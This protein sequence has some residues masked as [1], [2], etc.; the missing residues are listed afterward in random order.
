[1]TP[2][3]HP[4]APSERLSI[5]GR[6]V[7]AWHGLRYAAADA[8]FAPPRPASGRIEASSLHE[9][10]V[11]PQLPSRLSAAMGAGSANPQSEDAFYLNL[12]APS[13]AQGLP[14]VI[15]IHGGAWM[16]GGGAMTWYDG[17][18][19]AAEGLVVINVNYR[20][21]PLGHLGHPGAHPLPIP[22]ADLLLAL[23]W[24]VDHAG[25]FGGD[26]GRITAMGQSAGG[27]YAHLLT[28]LPETRGLI[29]RAALSSM[30]TRSPWSPQQQI[31]VTA[32]ADSKLGGHLQHAATADVLRAGMSALTREPAQLGHAPSA[33]L[34]VMSAGLPPKLLDPE[35]AAQACHADAV[36]IRFTAHESAA[37]F[38]NTPEQRNATQGQVDEAL[39]RWPEDD[40]PPQLRGE[41]GFHGASSG[42]SPYQ[43][44]VAASTWRQFQKFP[45][46][47]A[48]ELERRG[49]SVR[50]E[51]FETES[52][53]EGFHSGHCFDLPFQFG[54]LHAWADAPML[55]GFDADRFAALSRPLIADLAAFA[56]A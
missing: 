3:F 26:A 19:L 39:S 56:R 46:E 10:P 48:R 17:S 38:F 43:Q 44:L 25:S 45:A 49:T 42:L 14:V 52:R 29:H 51:R 20:L 36:Y 13:D 50:L 15:F 16:T 40:L 27:W 47:Y 30:G 11:F 53:L 31:E 6:P 41:G 24:I 8:R 28:V 21:G 12:W 22:A 5:D 4:G 37:F 18:R 2:R 55:A 7:H 34:P 33:F 9:V 54:H 32:R 35:W 1:M 23:Q